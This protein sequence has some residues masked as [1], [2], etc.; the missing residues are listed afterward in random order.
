MKR[1][2]LL[3]VED[4]YITGADLQ[5]GLEEMGYE[6][7]LVV[8]S[9]EEAVEQ[10]GVLCPDAIL[11]DI[12]LRGALSGIEA[13]RIIRER[14]SIPII[15]LTAHSDDP[16]F[17]Q[18]IRT[19]PFGFII[20]PYELHNLRTTIEMALFK[21]SMETKLRES[22]RTVLALLNATPDAFILI[23]RQKMIVA[24]NDPM[25]R[26]LA[27]K[28]EELEGR[29]IGDCV[30]PGLL[31]P[32]DAMLDAIFSDGRSFCFEDEQAG[33][34]IETSIYPVRE[35]DGQISRIALQ[36]HDISWRKHMEDQLKSAGIEQIEQN[37]E[38]FQI[39]N[40]QIRTPLQAIMLYISIGEFPYR[41]QI[42]DQVKVIDSLV[43]KLDK[44]WLE[45]EKVRTFLLRHY[46]EE[47][48]GRA[49]GDAHEGR[50]P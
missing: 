32:D 25:C 34:W 49:S 24:V 38:Q 39:L 9:G 18:A 41:T 4:E 14:Q 13:A 11:M 42:E 19:E 5:T 16:T 21:Y 50:Q 36:S 48:G 46:Q 1:T 45:S 17:Q 26:R 35:P 8:D 31:Y 12:T 29:R 2:R 3:V 10:A 6:V 15:F 33:A 40:D 43:G 20:K 44:G 27:A 23:D 30:R 47:T 7:P 37:M 28:R 22:E